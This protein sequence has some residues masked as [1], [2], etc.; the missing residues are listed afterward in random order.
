MKVANN[1]L[2][3]LNRL[4]DWSLDWSQPIL[5]PFISAVFGWS[6][7][8]SKAGSVLL[9]PSIVR[10]C[11][12]TLNQGI[13]NNGVPLGVSIIRIP[14][15]NSPEI[16]TG[17]RVSRPPC[18]VRFAYLCIPQWKTHKITYAIDLILFLEFFDFVRGRYMGG[19]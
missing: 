9:V 8:W 10:A 3:F 7:D 6:F 11:K 1:Q 13:V 2:T 17:C 5:K 16:L 12:E 4:V 18:N 15:Q 19:I 14:G